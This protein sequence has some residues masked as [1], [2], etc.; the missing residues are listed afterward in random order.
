MATPQRSE[1]AA[2]NLGGQ[3]LQAQALRQ[4]LKAAQR[5]TAELAEQ[6][7]QLQRQI[8]AERAKREAA[9]AGLAALAAQAGAGGVSGMP[10]V[11]PVALASCHGTVVLPG[12]AVA[13][14]RQ[15]RPQ[16]DPA[17]EWR[18]LVNALAKGRRAAS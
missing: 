18:M 3:G 14:L 6:T 10:A 7:A 1:A 5:R 16:C 4:R 9:E 17:A 2:R 8:A 11:W 15:A 13:V 12:G